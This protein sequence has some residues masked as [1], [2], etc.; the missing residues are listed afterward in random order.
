M[1]SQI[2]KKLPNSPGVYF[3]KKGK[4][5]LY[6]GKATTLKDRVKSYFNKDIVNTR[7]P[8]IVK[9]LEEASNV[10][11]IKTDSVLEALILEAHQIKKHQPIY[12]TK[13]K[14]NKSFNYVTFTKEDFPQIII[15]RGSGTYGPF[16]H[17]REL[18]EALKI[19]R[20]IFPYRDNKCKLNGRPCFNAQI[21]LCPGMCAGQITKTEYKRT[22]RH[23]KLFFEGKK[24]QLVKSLEKEMKILAKD[25]KFEEADK[26]KKTIF[27]LNH[28]RDVSLLKQEASTKNQEAGC[29]IE[30]YDIAHISGTSAVGVMVVV[31]DGEVNKSQYRKFKIHEDKNNDIANLQEVLTRRSNHPE[32]PRPDLIVV[33]GG[34]AQINVAKEIFKDINVVSVVKDERHKAKEIIGL[35]IT[36][37]QGPALDRAILLANAEAHRFAINYHRNLRGRGFKI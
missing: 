20:R 36:G 22:I 16:P 6:I 5:I 25:R 17:S 32:W 18:K 27:A 35:K 28:I 15:T 8:L 13:E 10:S 30:A 14:D 4:N 11:F 29:R 34:V 2:L 24:N 23:L 33:D 19:I 3:F 26:V 21:S 9:M 31:E 1:K 37:I 7:G 12:N